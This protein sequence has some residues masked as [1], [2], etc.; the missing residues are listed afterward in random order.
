MKNTTAMRLTLSLTPTGKPSFGKKMS[1]KNTQIALGSVLFT[2]T[3]SA[4]LNSIRWKDIL[5]KIQIHFAEELGGWV[6]GWW[7]CWPAWCTW[8]WTPWTPSR[9]GWLRGCSA[10]GTNWCRWKPIVNSNCDNLNNIAIG[11]LYDG[12]CIVCSKLCTS[13]LCTLL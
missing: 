2:C 8:G 12:I 6:G 7:W 13:R 10:R 3:Y 11:L 5:L 4:R 1:C 9:G